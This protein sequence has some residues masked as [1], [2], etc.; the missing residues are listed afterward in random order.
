MIM[1]MILVIVIGVA[2][3]VA[4]VAYTSRM[5]KNKE[6]HRLAGH[7]AAQQLDRECL[8]SLQDCTPSALTEAH[9]QRGI[10]PDPSVVSAR[11][12]SREAS[13]SPTLSD[14]SQLHK[15]Q[16]F[17]LQAVA[18]FWARTGLWQARCRLL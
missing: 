12:M 11:H 13:K 3:V 15:R 4:A 14:G 1:Q 7:P 8:S 9:T 10:G 16:L 6:R 17:C 5:R 2:V 18:A